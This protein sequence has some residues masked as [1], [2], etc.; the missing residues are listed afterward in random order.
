MKM[1]ILFFL[2]STIVMM[3]YLAPRRRVAERGAAD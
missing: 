1:L 3:S 2:M